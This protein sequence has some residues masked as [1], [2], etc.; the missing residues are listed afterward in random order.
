M[1]I[2]LL[3]S[4]FPVLTYCQT[5]PKVCLEG[6]ELCF[7]GSW[8]STKNSNEYAAFQGIRYA[9]APV[10]DL[11]FKSPIAYTYD[12]N[13]IDVSTESEVQ[14]PQINLILQKLE[15]EEDC[16]LLNIYTP[17]NVITDGNSTNP[18]LPVMIWIHGGGFTFGSGKIVK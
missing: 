9:Q 4:L 2:F 12:K 11:R 6:S 7:V 3:I 18:K 14:C 13:L 17:K 5:P 15:G 16:L 8:I 10:G 1:Y